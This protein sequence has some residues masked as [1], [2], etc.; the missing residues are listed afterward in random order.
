M[1]TEASEGVD[2][3]APVTRFTREQQEWN[4][5]LRGAFISYCLLHSSAATRVNLRYEGIQHLKN[6]ISKLEVLFLFLPHLTMVFP[7]TALQSTRDLRLK[8][9]HKG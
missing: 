3:V 4:L 1:S 9:S 2:M 8:L 6:T 5:D 7:N